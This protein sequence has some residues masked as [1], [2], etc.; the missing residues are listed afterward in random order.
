MVD[1][2]PLALL[3]PAGLLAGIVNTIA[4]GG[5]FLTLPLLMMGGLPEQ[6]ANGTNRVAILMQ[7]AY[8]SR[9]YD[10]HERL[11]RRALLFLLAALLPGAL[12]GVYLASAISPGH[13]RQA[14]GVLFVA[15]AGLMLVQRK[16][17]MA[18]PS[19][20]VGSRVGAAV[21][22]FMV[23]VYG[24]F[25]QAGV[26]LLLLV[27]MAAF[28]GRDLAA[29][30]GLKQ[31]VVAAWTLPA[32]AWFAWCGQVSWAP[33]LVLGAGN[34][35]GALVGAKLAIAKGN[36]LIFSLVVIVMVATAIHLLWPGR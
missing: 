1:W 23:G 32:V 8:A 33:G 3:F 22:F 6:V 10:R 2:L 20:P 29:S 35:L 17:L 7:T 11:D 15:F 12:V 36:R 31:A 25:L 18:R 14:M 26:G 24:G 9:V 19:R 30:N 4:G 27:S 28:L 16:L 5:S 13:F 34:L 21:V